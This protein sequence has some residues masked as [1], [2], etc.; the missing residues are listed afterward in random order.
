IF[1]N[2]SSV[3]EGTTL[4]AVAAAKSCAHTELDAEPETTHA[5]KAF[6]SASI[7][8]T[9]AVPVEGNDAPGDLPV[10]T[11]TRF[12]AVAVA[13]AT[14][15]LLVEVAPIW[16]PLARNGLIAHAAAIVVAS[17]TT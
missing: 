15:L 2:A 8:A 10:V 6:A 11:F 3:F 13:S 12:V 9:G 4:P 7:F 5:F 16:P 17:S 14:P 1:M